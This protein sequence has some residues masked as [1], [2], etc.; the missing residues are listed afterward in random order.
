[1]GAG[2]VED[3][4]VWRVLLW[5]GLL[6]LVAIIGS[7]SGVS[8]GCDRVGFPQWLL[9]SMMTYGLEYL[10]SCDSWVSGPWLVS[11]RV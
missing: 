2:L 10:N 6:D 5:L 11:T 7:W 1:M 9:P 8:I 3:L 4:M